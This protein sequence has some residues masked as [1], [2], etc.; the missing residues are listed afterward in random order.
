MLK[1]IVIAVAVVVVGCAAWYAWGY[2]TT[3]GAIQALRDETH[4]TG[5]HPAATAEAIPDGDVQAHSE[6]PAGM[7]ADTATPQQFYNDALFSDKERVEW[8][9]QQLSTPS[10]LNPRMSTQADALERLKTNIAA[11][12][13]PPLEILFGGASLVTP[14]VNN[15]A[16]EVNYQHAVILAAALY[17]PNISKAEKMV[18]AGYADDEVKKLDGS[19]VSSLVSAHKLPEAERLGL[20]VEIAYTPNVSDTPGVIV[21]L[22]SKVT[23]TTTPTRIAYLTDSQKS[24]SGRPDTEIRQSFMNGRWVE[25]GVVAEG[26]AGWIPAPE[27]RNTYPN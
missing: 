14:N 10:E 19:L 2:F 4:Q 22:A 15:S 6:R 16:N 20:D 5:S 9:D 23:T 24:A 27:L 12:H 13:R 3:K 21:D 8:A 11:N 7:T 25:T 17:E 18:A 26:G 1:Y